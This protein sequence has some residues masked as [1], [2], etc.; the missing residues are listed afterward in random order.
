MKEGNRKIVTCWIRWSFNSVFASVAAVESVCFHVV[1]NLPSSLYC[2]VLFWFENSLWFHHFHLCVL[3]ALLMCP[4]WS[5]LSLI[6]FFVIWVVFFVAI[7]NLY[8]GSILAEGMESIRVFP[9]VSLWIQARTWVVLVFPLS[10]H[11][12][13]NCNAI[14]LWTTPFPTQPKW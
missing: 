10:L 11:R 12:R 14:V 7:G 2:S 8:L 4:S 13:C 1:F 6:F 3:A 5:V 9:V